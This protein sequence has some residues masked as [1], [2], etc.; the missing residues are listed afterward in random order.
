MLSLHQINKVPPK[1]W[2]AG[3]KRPLYVYRTAYPATV[4]SIRGDTWH[5]DNLEGSPEQKA[6]WG[7]ESTVEGYIPEVIITMVIL[8]W[9]MQSIYSKLLLL[10]SCS[11]FYSC[12]S[13]LVVR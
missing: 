5:P 11:I 4:T 13:D 2:P 12:T 10:G 6:L 9:R 7:K 1:D 8:S 3:T